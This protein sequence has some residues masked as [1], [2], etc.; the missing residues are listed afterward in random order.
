VNRAGFAFGLAFGFLIAAARLNDYNVIHNMLLL[1]EPDVYLLMGSAVMTAMVLLG[2]LRARSWRTLNGPLDI[3]PARL[4]RK[5]VA[6]SVIFGVGWAIAGTCP[7]PALA[8]TVGGG[9]LGL[10]VVAGLFLGI[11]LRD[12]IAMRTAAGTARTN[13]RVAAAASG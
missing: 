11:A 7:G 9:L 12:A 3:T 6:G 5:H 4:E 13:V 1:R 2:V 8:M 10:I